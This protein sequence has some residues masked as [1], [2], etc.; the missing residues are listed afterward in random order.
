MSKMQLFRRFILILAMGSSL[1]SMQAEARTFPANVK[2]GILKS[3]AAPQIV[4]NDKLMATTPAT[5]IYNDAN[6]IVMPAYLG[7]ASKVVNYTLNTV[8]QVD[9]IW[10]LTDAEASVAVPKTDTDTATVVRPVQKIKVY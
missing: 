7:S 5:R 9:K 2:R 10:I 8:G 1:L 4:I 3:A 6:L